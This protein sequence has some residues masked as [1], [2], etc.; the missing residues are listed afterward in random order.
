[1]DK[2]LPH[3]DPGTIVSA[4]KTNLRSKRSIPWTVSR[5]NYWLLKLAFLPRIKDFQF[6]QFYPRGFLDRV[7]IVS[8]SSL[9]PCELLTRAHRMGYRIHQVPLTYYSPN[10]G[11]QSKCTNLHNIRLTLRDIVKLK[12]ELLS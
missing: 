12:R 10:N 8:R 5:T 7:R 4:Y 3:L 2:I 9:I 1:M 6:V 11:R